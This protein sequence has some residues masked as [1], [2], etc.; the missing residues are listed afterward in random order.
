M[1]EKR[2]ITVTAPPGLKVPVHKEDGRCPDGLPVLLVEAD[3]VCRVAYSSST[4]RAIKRG[5]L[6]PCNMAGTTVP[7]EQADCP[8][9]LGDGHDKIWLKGPRSAAAL[10]AAEQ[11]AAKT[12]GS[13]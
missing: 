1:E 11:A 8:K 5:D 2:Y 12:E 6:V 10:A 3:T 9:P 7:L 4:R 13:K